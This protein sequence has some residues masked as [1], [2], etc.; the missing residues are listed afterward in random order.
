MRKNVELHLLELVYILLSYRKLNRKG[1]N[2]LIQAYSLLARK[3]L[4]L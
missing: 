4:R 2:R 3:S 1:G